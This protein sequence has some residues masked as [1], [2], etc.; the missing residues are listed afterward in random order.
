MGEKERE[1]ELFKSI[2]SEKYFV[3]ITSLFS[4]IIGALYLFKGYKEG[5]L[6]ATWIVIGLN[7]LY[8]PFSIIF[9]KKYFSYYYLVYALVLIFFNA[10]N[11]T[12]LHNNYTSL[13]IIFIIILIMPKIKLQAIIFYMIVISVA[14][15]LN[16]EKIYLYFLHVTR[17]A[18]FYYIFTSVME[19]KYKR[20]KLIL[21]DD[22]I[23]ILTLLCQ[24]RLQKSIQ[25]EGYSESTIYRRLKAAMKRNNLS[26][27]DL[28]EEF[29]KEYSNLLKK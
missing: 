18:W 13:F 24:N 29:K 14:Y 4:F 21:Y 16:E 11:K 12:Y 27:Q 5:F 8:I 20:N 6:I 26:K 25:F 1:K 7:F 19:S 15:A 10:F 22:E 17:T 9:K 2:Y 28:L 3:I 23:K